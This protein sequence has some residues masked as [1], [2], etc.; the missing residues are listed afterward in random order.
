MTIRGVLLAAGASTRFGANKLLHCLPDGIPIVVAAARTLLAALP[1]SV[2]VVRAED[3]PVARVLAPL[4]IAVVP[5]L[6]S[7]EGMGSSLA[8]GVTA[9]SEARGWVVALAD[10]PWIQPATIARVAQ[11]LRDGAMIAAPAYL[12][13]RGHPVGF[14]NS[15]RAHLVS[16]RG[17]TG[18]RTVVSEYQAS[19]TLLESDD[20]AIVADIDVV[21]DLQPRGKM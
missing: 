13:Q 8:C 9:T 21:S 1:S 3:D 2:V 19:L 18:A 7:G 17:E 6:R 15:L 4:G 14:S 5:C 12:G 20:P 11:A 10:M 16:L